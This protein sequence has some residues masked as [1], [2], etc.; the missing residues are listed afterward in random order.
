MIKQWRILLLS[1][2]GIV[3]V[4]GVSRLTNPD[5]AAYENFAID[6]IGNLASDQC[7]RA[8]EGL[9]ILLQGACRAA[10]DA[11]KPQLS[12]LIGTA[13]R[14]Q[15]YGLFSIYQSD[16]SI[17]TANLSVKVESIGIFNHFFIYKVP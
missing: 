13:T 5:Q 14:R 7:D 15:D 8:P 16:I 17:P 9:G 1:M 4:C 10:I 11:Y 6:Q 12:P 3:A 2:L